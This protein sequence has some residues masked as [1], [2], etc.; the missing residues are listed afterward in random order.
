MEILVDLPL[1]PILIRILQRIFVEIINFNLPVGL[2]LPFFFMELLH[3]SRTTRAGFLPGTIFFLELDIMKAM[4]LFLF[5]LF[6][7]LLFVI[8]F[9]LAFF[10]LSKVVIFKFQKSNRV[11]IKT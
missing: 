3:H 4:Y 8:I 5:Y 1:N 2:N 6:I 9:F 7:N 10:N 11:S